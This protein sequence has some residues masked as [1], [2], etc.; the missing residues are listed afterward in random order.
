MALQESAEAESSNKLSK[1]WIQISRHYL[2]WLFLKY[3]HD[4]DKL[5]IF[6][7]GMKLSVII[8]NLIFMVAI[9]KKYSRYFLAYLFL[10][11]FTNASTA[12]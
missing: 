3:G 11:S 10:I 2:I 4:G 7:K 12:A 9:V 8:P 6:K 1:T 5:K